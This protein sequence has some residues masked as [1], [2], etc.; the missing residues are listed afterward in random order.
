MAQAFRRL[1]SDVTVV[2]MANRILPRED[3]DVADVVQRQ[4]QA[5]GVRYRL[6]HHRR[7]RQARRCSHRA[8]P[9]DAAHV[10]RNRR[11]DC[12]I[13]PDAR[14]GSRRRT[15]KAWVSTPPASMCDNGRIVC[16]RFA[17]TR[18]IP[19]SHVVGDVAG[20]H[21]FTHVAE[22]HAGIILRQ[23]ICSG[24]G[25]PSH[26]RSFPGAHITD[27]EL[28][29]VGL[30]ET[31]ARAHGIAHRVYRFPFVDVDRARAEGETVGFAKLLTDRRGRLLGAAIVGAD[32]GELIAECVLAIG[33]G[34]KA[35]DLGRAIHT[36]PTR[37]QVTRR[38]ASERR[39]ASLTPSTRAWMQRL[40]G[41]RGG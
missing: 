4:L 12:R 41:L 5:E 30:S 31:D 39:K 10:G 24:C 13:A 37:S 27:P 32:A 1:G 38:A 11:A 29:R 21:P 23:T 36:Y 3:A 20:G 9:D 40:F 19:T 33:K 2:D 8:H 22:H 16:R 18:R 7:R 14:R 34:M 6:R 17:A 35:D 26:R 25:G 28:A 15:S